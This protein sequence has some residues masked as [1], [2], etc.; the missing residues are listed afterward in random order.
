MSDRTVE[1]ILKLT[2]NQ[3]RGGTQEARQA[4]RN[5]GQAMNDAVMRGV[6]PLN[7]RLAATTTATNAYRTAIREGASATQASVAASQAATQAVAG[8][9]RSLQ[10]TQS[11]TAGLTQG[12]GEFWLATQGVKTAIGTVTRVAREFYEVGERAAQR[13]RTGRMFETLSGGAQQAERNL[14][15][16]R[17]ATRYTIS[18]AEALEGAVGL[19]GMR[20]ARN[21][22]ELA[23]ITQQVAT[24][25]SRFAGF[26]AGRSIQ[27]FMFAIENQSVQ[28]LGEFGLNVSDVTRRFEELQAAGYE[29]QEAFRIATLEAMNV[30]FERIGGQA[31]DA[32]TEFEQFSAAGADLTAM[33][34]DALLPALTRLV[35]GW[36]EWLKI[37]T[38][39]WAGEFAGQ[40]EEAI[41]AAEGAEEF[42]GILQRAAEQSFSLKG[43]ALGLGSPDF[44]RWR[45][46][47]QESATSVDEYRAGME[48]LNAAIAEHNRQVAR[49]QQYAS[50]V[51]PGAPPGVGAALEWWANR[52]PAQEPFAVDWQAE[53]S[54]RMRE[55]YE[56]E[57]EAGRQRAEAL[58]QA[59]EALVERE[60]E[61]SEKRQ[62]VLEDFKQQSADL[63]RRRGRDAYLAALRAGWAAEDAERQTARRRA[64]I[65]EQFAQ[66]V[67]QAEATYV[68][69]R[70]Q[71]AQQHARRREDIERDYQ[72]RLADI[73]QRYESDAWEASLNRDAAAMLR[74]QRRREEDL[75]RA[76]QDRDEQERQAG[77]QYQD[78]LQQAAA[79]RQ[80]SLQQ[81]QEMRAAAQAQLEESLREELEA[82]R[83]A[84]ERARLE[85]RLQLAWQEQDRLLYLRRRITQTTAT[86]QAELQAA[87]AYYANLVRLERSYQASRLPTAPARGTTPRPYAAGGYT[88]GGGLALLHPHEFVLNA[89]TTR[90]LERA[91]G[92]PLT[93]QNVAQGGGVTVNASFTGMG[94]QDTAWFERRLDD[95]ARNL[96]EL[97]T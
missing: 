2:T 89:Q 29:V 77:Q 10:T 70:E 87:A 35:S 54:R 3:F 96:A 33:L 81:A 22:Q 15:A 12:L 13:Q 31:A 26:S 9:G 38:G 59:G 93:Q 67:A 1:I 68:R 90:R 57:R 18:E 64:Q 62:A 41:A 40:I 8:L 86:Y 69:A 80:Q 46:A 39:R 58:R 49:R 7:I 5:L 83:R 48:A 55:A 4:L 56:A 52:Q 65:Q 28:R 32:A 30:Q 79:A 66:A 53:Q 88:G 34:E 72:R 45:V 43:Q 73:Q 92:G 37:P 74:A 21:S 60:R 11:A 42:A 19:L 25:G 94:Q 97:L 51:G 91:V 63:E 20:L 95:F 61:I 78:A 17:Q 84:E 75:A 71:A 6:N 23:Q 50:V 16:M 14:R 76:R 44:E 47:I 24:L 82:R 85:Q 36:N 27:Q